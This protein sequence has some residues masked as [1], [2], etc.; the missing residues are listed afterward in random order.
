[1]QHGWRGGPNLLARIIL[2]KVVDIM[3]ALRSPLVL[4][5]STAILPD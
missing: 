1:L 5:D 3:Q 2:A 4:T